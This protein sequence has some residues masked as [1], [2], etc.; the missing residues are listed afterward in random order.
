MV[1]LT[2]NFV[3]LR[4]AEDG[5]AGADFSVSNFSESRPGT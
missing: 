3:T 4:Q 1:Y 2:G 5:V